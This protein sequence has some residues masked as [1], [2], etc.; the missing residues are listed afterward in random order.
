MTQ[1]KNKCNDFEI[2]VNNIIGIFNDVGGNLATGPYATC[3][4]ECNNKLNG[5]I[6]NKTY[7]IIDQDQNIGLCGCSPPG[8][9][10]F[11]IYQM[12]YNNI[13]PKKF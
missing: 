10:S 6:W 12:S 3:P 5:S 8:C 2:K 11:D 4:N 13:I 9:T 7:K 1:E